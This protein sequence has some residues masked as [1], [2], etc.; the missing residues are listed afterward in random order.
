MGILEE[1]VTGCVNNDKKYQDKLFKYFYRKMFIVCVG[2]VKDEDIANDVVQDGFI[3]IFNS[4]H[5]LHSL[6]EAKIYS[7]VKKIMI[8]T[9]IDYI[10]KNKKIRYSSEIN[11]TTQI[12]PDVSQDEVE[13]I[14]EIE[15]KAKKALSLIPKLPN[16]YKVVF[17]K[18]VLENKQ[19]KEIAKELGIS[20]S[21][22]KT[23]YM[24]AKIKLRKMLE[25]DV[26]K[27]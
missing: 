9:A 8:N 20:E 18:Y 12:I 23:H 22:S 17:T 11:K 6:N 21:T 5:T 2:Y 19:H 1:I 10:R 14:N 24:R 15:E 4:I 16:C 27:Q 25:K 7:W 26:Y 13:Y 3:K